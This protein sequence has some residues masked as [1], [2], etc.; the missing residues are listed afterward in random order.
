MKNEKKIKSMFLLIGFTVSI[1]CILIILSSSYRLYKS[2]SEKNNFNIKYSIIQVQLKDG[3]K[4]DMKSFTEELED[5][6]IKD[7]LTLEMDDSIV[8]EDYI[9]ATKILGISGEIDLDEFGKVVSKGVDDIKINSGERVAIVGEGTIKN[10]IEK[11]GERYIKVFDDYYKVIGELKGN[12]YL[13]YHVIVPLK[14]LQFYN[15][16]YNVFN[17]LIK[18]SDLEKL[19]NLSDNYE[20]KFTNIPM[21]DIKKEILEK[22]PETKDFI[23]NLFLALINMMLFSIFF[24]KD[25]K[26]ELAIMR[27]LGA[28][29]RHIIKVVFIKIVRIALISIP[30]ALTM[31]YKTITYI[32][33]ILINSFSKLNLNLV[34]ISL[35]LAGI[36]IAISVIVTCFNALSFKVLKEIR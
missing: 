31:A 1:Y 30:I 34:F 22:L 26:R 36:I 5:I 27:V 10:S 3:S 32:N 29:N 13:A 15:E 18:N 11:E 23:F 2:S 16:K 20:V 17:Y 21:V 35:G 12:D 9:A 14:S 33:N 4:K 25:M 8:K 24:A 7:I 6:N 28:R 19:N